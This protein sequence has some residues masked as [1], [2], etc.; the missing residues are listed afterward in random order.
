M[1]SRLV[2][3]LFAGVLVVAGPV[4]FI[5]FCMTFKEDRGHHPIYRRREKT[6]YEVEPRGEMS[7]WS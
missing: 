2:L 1:S 6:T 7:R 5:V 4:L 3:D